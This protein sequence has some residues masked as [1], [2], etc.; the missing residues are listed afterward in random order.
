MNTKNLTT[1]ECGN[2][3]HH[4]GCICINIQSPNYGNDEIIVD[5]EYFEG[6]Y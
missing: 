5:C 6:G 4:D 2:C 1:N 3:G